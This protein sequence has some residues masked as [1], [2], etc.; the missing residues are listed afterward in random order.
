MRNK[1]GYSLIEMLIVLALI[2]AIGLMM[3]SIFGQGLSLYAAE[4][5]SANEQANMR[6]AL[7]SITNAARVADPATI[8]FSSGVLHIGSKTYYLENQSIKKSGAAIA[9]DIASFNVAI[10]G[11][12]LDI[13]V[14]NLYGKSISTSISLLG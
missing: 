11:G 10:S 3:Y 4:S 13:T 6:Q 9:N 5:K 1:K 14:V 12:I 8:T 2:S 7:S